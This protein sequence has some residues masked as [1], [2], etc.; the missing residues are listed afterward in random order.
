ME[1]FAGQTFTKA[2]HDSLLYRAMMD[3]QEQMEETT[4]IP[5]ML[6]LSLTRTKACMLVLDHLTWTT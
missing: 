6:Q 5:I 4:W 3:L 1:R 2:E